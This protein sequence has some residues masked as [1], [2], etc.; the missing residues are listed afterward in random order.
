MLDDSYKNAA[1]LIVDDQEANVDIL[2]GF[3]ENQGYT[4][5]KATIHPRT[6]V[7]LVKSFD[8]DIILLDL[9]MPHLSGFE[10]LSQ[11]KAVI[12]ANS[13]LPILVLTADITIES[14]QRA[15][16]LG[17]K[18]FLAKPYDLHEVGLNI[19]NLLFTRYLA[20]QLEN[21]N[22]ILEEKVKERTAYLEEKLAGLT[23]ANVVAES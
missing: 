17:A 1:I 5:L 2:V 19:K 6:A 12:A 22:I 9:L 7:A 20:Q 10:I 3:L 14:K 21:Q 13:Y 16:A 11:L 18:S 4:N 8:P 23:G 15:L